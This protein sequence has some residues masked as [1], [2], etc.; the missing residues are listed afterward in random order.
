MRPGDFWHQYFTINLKFVIHKKLCFYHL[1]NW[2]FSEDK[3]EKSWQS[4]FGDPP[5][6]YI[7]VAENQLS[8]N[9]K[10]PIAPVSWGVTFVSPGPPSRRTGA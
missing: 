6:Q 8:E 9:Q 10:K 3:A 4:Y 2:S 1:C 7:F 5:M